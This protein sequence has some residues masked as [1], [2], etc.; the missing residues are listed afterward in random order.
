VKPPPCHHTRTGRDALSSNA[1]DGV[2]T[3]TV[4]LPSSFQSGTRDPITCSSREA[5][6]G[7][8]GP[9]CTAS[10]T[11][12]HPGCGWGGAKRSSPTGDAA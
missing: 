9:A 4:R 1:R 11:P 8:A 2:W 10:L 3:L 12:V 5:A 7:T 6:C